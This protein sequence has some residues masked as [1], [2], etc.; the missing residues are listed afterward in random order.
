MWYLQESNQGHTDFQSVALPTELR[1]LRCVYLL[2]K[3]T[4]LPSG[5]CKYISIFKIDKTKLYKNGF[6]KFTALALQMNFIIDV[7]NTRV[8]L[9]LFKGKALLK[10]TFSS[11][12]DIKENCLLWLE[13]HPIVNVI[14]SSVGHPDIVKK[15]WFL[16]YNLIYLDHTTKAPFTNKYNTPKT[17]GVDRIALIA[18]AAA[19]YPKENVLVIDAG[20]C[21]TYDF[22]T[23][24]N[25]YLG[26]A[27]APGINIRFKSLNDYTANLP[28]LEIGEFSLIGTSTNTSILSGVLNGFV[29]EIDG[30]I[31]QYLK[32]YPNLTV[33]LTGGD[34]NF[35]A[36]KLKS[37]IF[38]I[39][40]F[41]LE[42]LNSI[43]IHNTD[44]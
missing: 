5:G 14:I 22:L 1:Y 30:V 13:E 42:G 12:E 18:A 40:N 20:T 10:M 24:K 44:E 36:K 9:A 34:A 15:D 25:E 7:G 16:N 35:L 41:L 32:E 28:L 2:C 31:G 3:Y 39:P 33:V 23:S 29:V 27:I 8:K 26:G 17:L 21:I 19:H 4:T 6:R 43:L 37:S 11:Y 38:A